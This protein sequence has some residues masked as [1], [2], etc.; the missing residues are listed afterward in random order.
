MSIPAG[1]TLFERK[2]SQKAARRRKE[3]TLYALKLEAS[4]PPSPP[5]PPTP[6]E[7]RPVGNDVPPAIPEEVLALPLWPLW[8]DEKFY[9]YSH[10]CARGWLPPGQSEMRFEVGRLMRRLLSDV[11]K[12][13]TPRVRTNLS[14]SQLMPYKEQAHSPD[15]FHSIDNPRLEY[16]NCGRLDCILEA[17]R[18]M[19]FDD[20][21]TKSI[22]MIAKA[23]IPTIDQIEIDSNTEI[24]TKTASTRKIDPYRAWDVD[25]QMRRRAN[26]AD[27]NGVIN[28]HLYLIGW[29]G[30]CF[31]AYHWER[32]RDR[33]NIPVGDRGDTE[34]RAGDEDTEPDPAPVR[35]P[36]KMRPSD[37]DIQFPCDPTSGPD[38]DLSDD[39]VNDQHSEPNPGDPEILDTGSDLKPAIVPG[40]QPSLW[41]DLRLPE[42][43]K[44]LQ[45]VILDAIRASDEDQNE[46]E[47]THESDGKEE[48]SDGVKRKRDFGPAFPEMYGEVCETVTARPV[49]WQATV[50]TDLDAAE[51]L[52]ISKTLREESSVDEQLDEKEEQDMEKTGED[53]SEATRIGSSDDIRSIRKT[54]GRKSSVP[55]TRRTR[56]GRSMLWID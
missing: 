12:F 20:Y 16:Y 32:P 2:N 10:C 53:R 55:P 45:Q 7:V 15:P 22:I 38:P 9:T 23:E 40:P 46:D 50:S 19:C 30:Y 31:R 29:I 37:L 18:S 11:E 33:L 43:Q 49:T 56:P 8:T 52:G 51:E 26:A 36:G 17:T 6:P 39:S 35:K 14:E 47:Q 25:R 27:R 41:R 42:N 28:R 21:G 48:K 4:R 44:F 13:A 5:P 3:H 24:E 54:G 34:S 1:K